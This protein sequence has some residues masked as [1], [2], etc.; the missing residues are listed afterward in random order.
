MDAEARAL[1]VSLEN[2]GVAPFVAVTPNAQGAV[3]SSV[4][5]ADNASPAVARGRRGQTSI[6]ISAI[7]SHDDQGDPSGSTS[8]AEVRRLAA[9]QNGVREEAGADATAAGSSATAGATRVNEVA[10]TDQPTDAPRPGAQTTS[11][12][13]SCATNPGV[14]G[15]AQPPERSSPTTADT[16]VASAAASAPDAN[17]ADETTL[18]NEASTTEHHDDANADDADAADDDDI[19]ER[20]RRQEPAINTDPDRALT[21]LCARIM[22]DLDGWNGDRAALDEQVRAALQHRSGG[23]SSSS[24]G[25]G[26]SSGGSGTGGGG[27]GD[28]TAAFF[29][30]SVHDSAGELWDARA[31]L[32]RM[33]VAQ[34]HVARARFQ[35]ALA[36]MQLAAWVAL[37]VQLPDVQCLATHKERLTRVL[38]ALEAVDAE[39][40]RRA[41]WRCLTAGERWT[42]LATEFGIGVAVILPSMMGFSSK[43]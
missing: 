23:G 14:A 20:C 1:D 15:H 11:H 8:S 6:P 40:N 34:A 26:N 30:T 13:D 7:V 4:S 12:D 19:N 5:R 43:G 27:G 28:D 31:L 17:G 29:A 25:G 21:H 38:D 37:R 22:A 2:W 10:G 33:N 16:T 18:V 35:H 42:A 3:S 24:N 36:L 41:W 32:R 9:Q 39:R